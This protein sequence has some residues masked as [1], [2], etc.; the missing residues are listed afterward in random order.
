MRILLVNE[1]GGAA[2][3]TET[4]VG[5]IASGLTRRG[6]KVGLLYARRG[7][8]ALPTVE[9]CRQSASLL[10]ESEGTDRERLRELA[11][12]FRPDVVHVNRLPRWEPVTWLSC[13]Y[14]TVVFLHDHFPLA[15]PG[16][17]K[18]LKG[19][20][21]VCNRRVGPFCLVA[22]WVQKCGSRRP[23]VHLARYATAQKGLTMPS[24]VSRFL[25]ASRYMKAELTSNGIEAARVSVVGL[26]GPEPWGVAGGGEGILYV[27]RLTA[28]KGA[29]TLVEALSLLKPR[30]RAVFAGEGPLKAELADR[31]AA[32]GL[33]ADFCGWMGPEALQHAFEQAA[34]VV[35]PSLWPE[36][37]GLVGLEAMA[38]ARPIVAFDRGG[39]GEWLTDGENGRC[40]RESDP[41]ALAEAMGGLL[42]DSALRRHMGER[43][44]EIVAA[45]FSAGLH[46]DR[47]EAEYRYAASSSTV[48]TDAGVA[49]LRAHDLG[50]NS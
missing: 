42:S 19:A 38:A 23:W 28:D 22:P 34:V 18:F 1:W 27:G 46:F 43:G 17:G 31:A 35:V 29:A 7:R 36:P 30:P 8:P 21:G 49:R 6:H 4:Y 47:L 20:Q 9:W 11:A 41:K 32:L 48:T 12:D 45:R 24:R 3:G 33:E 15:C 44:R 26:P 13:E 5:E 2:G 25:V 10:G 39:I 50:K 14:P 40:L 16:Y 37:F